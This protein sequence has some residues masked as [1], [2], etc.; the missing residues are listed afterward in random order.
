MT[1]E[2]NESWVYFVLGAAVVAYFLYRRADTMEFSLAWVK[3]VGAVAPYLLPPLVG[4]VFNVVSRR[5]TAR[6][7]AQWDAAVRL[8]GLMRE[9]VN[10]TARMSTGRSGSFSADIRLTRVAFYVFDRS[11]KREPM[12]IMLRRELAGQFVAVDAALASSDGDGPEVV[13]VEVEGAAAFEIEFLSGDPRGWWKDLRRSMGKSTDL[14]KLRET[15]EQAE[16]DDPGPAYR[17]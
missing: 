13:R 1:K 5:R 8:E 17:S 9:E 11:Y 12:K 14:A 16:T 6:A 2:R 4:V 15:V 7:K 10:V 3:R